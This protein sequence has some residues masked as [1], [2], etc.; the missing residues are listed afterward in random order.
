VP[1]VD[2][3]RRH[4]PKLIVA[5]LLTFASGLVDIVGFLGV[6][7]LFTAHLTGTTVHLGQELADQ[8]WGQ[9]LGAAVI[10][11]AFM[12]GSLFGRA[13]IEIGSR[14]LVRRVA[15]ITLAIESLVLLCVAVTSSLGVIGPYGSVALLAGAMGIQTATLTGV[16]PLTVH[17]TFVTGMMNKLAQLVSHILFRGHDLRRSKSPSGASRQDQRREIEMAFFLATVWVCYV[18]G[19]AFGTWSFSLW[20][21]YALFV[22]IALLLLSLIVDRYRP[23]A[24]REEREQSER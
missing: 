20:R 7:R 2:F 8:G 1:D 24:I 5:L 4:G 14:R 18:A 21:L 9:A 3:L 12:G 15:S 10:V 11:A 23:L 6:F 17:T 13:V 22:A 19:A 16:G